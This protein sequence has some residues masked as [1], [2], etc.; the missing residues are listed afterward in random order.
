[1]ITSNVKIKCSASR[2]WQA[3]TDNSQLKEWY[4]DIPDFELKVGATFNFFEPGGEN[5]FHHRCQ[6]IEIIPNKK[7]SHTW[8]HPSRSKGESIVTWTINEENGETEVTLQ[9]EGIENFADAGPAFAPEN[10]QMGWDGF[11]AILKNYVYGIRKHNYQIEIDASAEKVWN[12]LLN[13]DTYRDWT[14]YFCEGSY[15]KGEL[16][17]GG[18]IHFLTP[19]GF[20]MYSNIVLY[21]PFTNILFQHIGEL[22]NFEEQP[23]DE[24]TEKW[25]GAFENYILKSNGTKTTLIAEIDLTPEHIA[26]FNKSFPSG[27]E[28]IKLLSETKSN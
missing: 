12:V 3:L 27:L 25:T 20:G 13:D 9:H 2:A 1:M 15:Y 5:L 11:M 28:K 16:K 7:F 23:I 14:S 24:A 17:Q 18:R 10:Y 21:T 6:I 4:F 26:M 19:E 8:T 22:V